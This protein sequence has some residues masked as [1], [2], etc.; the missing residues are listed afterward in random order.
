MPPLLFD[1]A[2]GLGGPAW[3][4]ASRERQQANFDRLG[5]P[6]ASEEE[7]R[8]SPIGEL[9]L[10]RFH[11]GGDASG[12]G[13][14]AG[15]FAA[16]HVIDVNDEF[17]AR[18]FGDGVQLSSLSAHEQGADLLGSCA[19]DENDALLALNG[20]CLRDAVVL[21]VGKG[22]H[23]GTP[24][25]LV[26][27]V[28][29]GAHFPRTIV[30]VGEGAQASLIEV[31][32]GEGADLLN[33]PVAELSVNDGA[34]LSYGSVQLLGK[35]AWHLAT[36]KSEVG[37]DATVSQL[38]AGLG[39][40]YDRMRTDVLL[41]GQGASSIL[42]STYLGHDDQVHDLR[43][44]QDHAAPRTVSD[45]LCKGAVDDASRSI[46]TG[47]IKVRHGAIRSDAR[48]S[49]HNLVLSPEAHADS[50]PNLDIEENDVRCSHASTVGPLDE[51]QRYY[52]ESRGISPQEADR[53]LVRGFF[54]DLL[55]RTP[56]QSAANLVQQRIEDRLGGG[57]S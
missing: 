43:T 3:L 25:V 1:S 51:D 45:L 23:A 20:A 50:V 5:I 8:Y 16:S 47:V 19:K 46:Y 26:H 48:Q 4:V 7:W 53:L 35:G 56:L 18:S 17:T 9:D 44:L 41:A 15:V 52:L 14:D 10:E 42:R 38:T 13:I 32:V 39:A 27:R 29:N 33:V 55:E 6:D 12:N 28:G 37:R 34:Q 49:N 11:L 31:F 24:I 54:R 36:V 57:A 21:E 2:H 40:S 30:R 22:V